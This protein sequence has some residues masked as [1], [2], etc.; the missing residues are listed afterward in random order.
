[1]KKIYNLFSV[2]WVNRMWRKK[3]SPLRSTAK[4]TRGTKVMC[5][6]T[7]SQEQINESAA[8]H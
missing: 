8:L 7:I 4:C 6:W 2:P 5:G 3:V 1:M